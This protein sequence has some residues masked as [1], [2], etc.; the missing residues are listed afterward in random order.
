[1]CFARSYDPPAHRIFGDKCGCLLPSS[2]S[3]I[4]FWHCTRDF[5]SDKI[6]NH[7]ATFWYCSECGAKW[8]VKMRTRP[9]LVID[10]W[11]IS[12][13]VGLPLL[14]VNAVRVRTYITFAHRGYRR[15][16]SM[17]AP[18]SPPSIFEISFVISVEKNSSPC[19]CPPRARSYNAAPPIAAKEEHLSLFPRH[20]YICCAWEQGVEGSAGRDDKSISYRHMCDR[21]YGSREQSAD[22]L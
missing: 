15:D 10:I 12:M 1:M 16:Q 7:A 22:A 2:L 13:R 18:P 8:V 19:S 9:D 20:I 21:V 17:R 6:R 14:V 11:E 3:T 5:I 4:N